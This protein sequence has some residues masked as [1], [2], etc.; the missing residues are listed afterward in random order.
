MN[1]G[2]KRIDVALGRMPRQLRRL[3]V[4]RARRLVRR[5]VERR[6]PEVGEDDVRVD[7]VWIGPEEDVG[8]FDVAVA[9]APS[10]AVRAAGVEALV[11]KRESGEELVID[12]PD[13]GFG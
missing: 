5:E 2:A 4:R 1:D 6:V 11:E 10:V 8:G 3:P 9:D 12:V 13:E 7:R